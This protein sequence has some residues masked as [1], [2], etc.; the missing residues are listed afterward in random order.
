MTHRAPNESEALHFSGTSLWRPP[1]VQTSF[2]VGRVD[3]TPPVGIRMRNWGYGDVDLST[4][5]HRPLTLTALAIS[6]RDGSG[7][8]LLITADLG[9]WR[10][11]RDESGVRGA[12]LE[13]FGLT[14][15]RVLLHLV[16]THAGPS[17]CLDDVDLP[18]GALVPAYLEQLRSA[19]VDACRLAMDDLSPGILVWGHGS[20]PLAVNRDQSVDGRVT[21]GF[22]P[23]T[24]ADR[25]LLVGRL[26][27][28]DGRIRA[29]VVNYACHPT[30]LGFDNSLLS[31]D[32]V[33]GLRERVEWATGGAPCLFL[34]GA[35]GDLSGPVQYLA[36]PRRADAYG[37]ALGYS[38]LGVL[39]SLP[40]A[41]TVLQLVRTVESGAPLALWDEV[42]GT[43][44]GELGLR[45]VRVDVQLRDLPSLAELDT[46]WADIDPRARRERLQR[47]E[48][49]QA[50]YGVSGRAPTTA[51]H[52]PLWVWR[53]GDAYVVA[54]PGEAYSRLQTELRARHPDKIVIVMN[55]TNGPGWVYLPPTEA[56][57]VD[58]YQTWQTVL[59]PGALEALIDEAD[60]LVTELSVGRVG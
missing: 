54:Q 48:R 25:T 20:S 26:T 43:W 9:W 17:I 57:I 35:S 37:D 42:P 21:L 50:T 14:A 5:V 29:T 46:R 18:G 31:P 23:E 51:V 10:S 1:G 52:H 47:S 44:P 3:I 8:R 39:G 27:G 4:G 19:A 36:D 55:L 40:P 15:D 30:T 24:P 7:L 28:E 32:F 13:A 56:F 22:D 11:V 49:L 2:G 6:G 16:H 58:R 12:V 41:G 45:Q 53:L 38:V 34:Q 33:G 59:R 60:A